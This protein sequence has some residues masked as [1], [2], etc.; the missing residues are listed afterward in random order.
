VG[1]D[2]QMIYSFRGSTPDLLLNF[3]RELP[4]AATY[5]MEENYRC[6]QDVT[7]LSNQI[8]HLN[9]QRYSKKAFT[10][11]THDTLIDLK[12]VT[13][14]FN[15]TQAV[16]EQIQSM[17]AKNPGSI[18][19]LYRNNLSA[20]PLADALH[21]MKINF[22]VR[23]LKMTFINHWLTQDLLQIID[24]AFQPDNVKLF[25]QIYYKVNGYISKMMIQW[26]KEHPPLKGQ[27]VLLHLKD[28]GLMTEVY[29]KKAVRDLMYQ[30]DAL[31]RKR[32]VQIIYH[33]V[34]HLG[35]G[36]Y[37]ERKKICSQEMAD[38]LLEVITFLCR[39]LSGAQGLREK[40]ES[41]RSSA[42]ADQS[43]LTLTT[44]HSSKGLEF[45]HVILVDVSEGLFPARASIKAVNGKQDLLQL[46]EER[47]L[48]YVAMT[49]TRNNLTLYA[50]ENGFRIRKSESRF[51]S[52]MRYLQT[53]GVLSTGW[54]AL[55]SGSD[56]GNLDE[57]PAG[58]SVKP[59]D[60]IL[61]R[62]FGPGQVT[63]VNQKSVDIRFSDG[64]RKIACDFIRKV[65]TI[66]TD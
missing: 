55:L 62:S 56:A 7:H 17:M 27:S 54:G 1:D 42:V 25:E 59:G 49:R 12:K 61:H 3:T 21:Q 66:H 39:D 4:D 31:T 43:A 19:L 52:E 32:Q 51:I 37:L 22:H 63:E 45:D 26:L 53:P 47:R 11:N 57:N 6:S 33:L 29:Q 5:F 64:I 36:Q 41:M 13:D 24:F 23:D 46:E 8:I 15:Q 14:G 44:I 34:D 9:K 28:S 65:L 2:D 16:V 38:Q 60:A 40:L 48:L 50:P 58:F 10:S 35:Y 30:F 20:I 18:G